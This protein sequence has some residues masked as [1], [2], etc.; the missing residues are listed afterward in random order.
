MM[1]KQPNSHHCFICGVK[2]VA[3]VRVAF[4]ETAN[5]SGQ[6]EILARFTGRF[7]HQ[8][9]PGRMHG[10]VITG[11]LDETIGRA[12]NI[13]AGEALPMT[14]GVTAELTVR[15]LQPVP[16]DAELTA[17]GRITRQARRIFEGTG[18]LYL[19]DGVIA[20][21]ATG[22]YW[23]MPLGEIANLEDRDLGWRVYLDEVVGR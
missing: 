14:W 20:V 4:Y 22:R 15:F 11:V 8:G 18:E 9:Y 3:G 2:N 16:L 19:P 12:I 1:N 5:A 17:R 21:T 10:G 23:K 7:Q 13:G 6:P